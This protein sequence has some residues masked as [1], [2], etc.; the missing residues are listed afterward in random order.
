MFYVLC[1]PR[2]AGADASAI[3]AFRAK[4]E[5]ARAAMVRAHITLVFG[6]RHIEPAQLVKLAAGIAATTAPFDIAIDGMEVEAHEHGDHNLMLKV[7][8]GREK[9]IALNKAFYAGAL[10]PERGAIEFVPHITVASNRDLKTVITAAPEA[11]R[12]TTVK[13]RVEA[14]DVA[15]LNGATLTSLGTIPLA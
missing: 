3:E 7:G 11:K 15:T 9:L 2:L 8:A 5:P 14:L 10:A 4:H 6:V 13:G 1:Y 12:L